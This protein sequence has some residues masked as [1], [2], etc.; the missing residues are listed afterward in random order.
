MSAIWTFEIDAL[1]A[2][3]QPETVRL[4]DGALY[5][6]ADYYEPRMNSSAIVYVSPNDGG[7]FKIFES[8]SIGD[9]TVIN[10]DG[11]LD[12]LIDYALDGRPCRLQQVDDG[13]WTSYFLGTV[14]RM[15]ENNG[16][17]SFRLKSLTEALNKPHPFAKYGGTNV[18]PDGVDGVATDIKGNIIPKVFGAPEQCAPVLVNTSKQIYQVS[19]RSGCIIDNVYEAGAKITKTAGA[20][21]SSLAD[22]LANAPAAGYWRAYQG[23]FRVTT[24]LL[25]TVTVDAH[26]GSGLAG[27][28]FEQIVIEAGYTLDSASKTALNTVG[29][30][31]LF[32]KSELSTADLLNR[33]VRSVGAYWYFVGNV[34]HAALF[35]MATGTPL[36]LYDYELISVERKATAIGSNGTKISKI[37]I[38]YD[39]LE[40][41]QTDFAGSVSAADRARFSQEYRKT[42]LSD[43]AVLARHPLSETLKIDDCCL[44]NKAD[45]D[46]VCARILGFA[47]LRIDVVAA[48]A[49]YK[50]IPYLPPINSQV[51]IYHKRLGY[52]EG[53]VL[54]VFGYK[55]DIKRKTLTLDLA[56]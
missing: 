4:S 22:L 45:A 51:K 33:I 39:P 54:T 43:A 1:N 35:Q 13:V 37:E 38:K 17:L 8:P 15:S 47:K 11:G 25:R 50:N 16:M 5:G 26:E 29:V 21:Y 46:A 9:V 34:V 10:K 40:T 18:L 53:K 23:Y 14:D 52:S 56:G 30:I 3:D 48:L 6:T 27:D 55:N 44:K 28:V 19:S 7:V 31:K 2:S 42:E 32:A 24:P 20:D 36:E 12:Y 49:A 41:V